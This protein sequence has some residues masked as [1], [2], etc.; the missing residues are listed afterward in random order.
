M[1]EKI[2]T[3]IVDAKAAA[4]QESAA[5]KMKQADEAAVNTAMGSFAV[6]QGLRL[7]GPGP[8]ATSF[9]EALASDSAGFSAF[10]RQPAVSGGSGRV[11]PATTA[12]SASGRSSPTLSMGGTSDAPLPAGGGSAS[13]ASRQVP[14]LGDLARDMG[15][16]TIA[17]MAD[18]AGCTR[19]EADRFLNLGFSFDLLSASRAVTMM[20]VAIVER[21]LEQRLGEPLDELVASIKNGDDGG[22]DVPGFDGFQENV[23]RELCDLYRVSSEDFYCVPNANLFHQGWPVENSPTEEKMGKVAEQL[24]ELLVCGRINAT[25][26][27]PVAAAQESA[28]GAFGGVAGGGSSGTGPS[29]QT[30]GATTN[31]TGSLARTRASSPKTE[32]RGKTVI[33]VLI[34]VAGLSLRQLVFVKFFACVSFGDRDLPH[35][36]DFLSWVRHYLR[37]HNAHG[38][39]N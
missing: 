39:G 32:S 15:A 35:V 18:R 36:H 37:E 14:A 16:P 34:I 4:R 28:S 31:A 19:E 22:G 8:K 21:M 24:A 29:R 38:L 27:T 20:K 23:L 13:V 2:L 10:S 9:G 5:N 17:E 30:S 26:P 12:G 7:C 25:A 11:S 3:S 33:L 6:S 1:Q